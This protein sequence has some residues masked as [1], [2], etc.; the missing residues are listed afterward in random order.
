MQG[1]IMSNKQISVHDNEIRSYKMVLPESTLIFETTYQNEN[2]TITFLNVLAYSFDGAWNQNIIFDIIPSK[3]EIFVDW[4]RNHK[5]TQKPFEY[6]F[7]INGI[8]NADIMMDFLKREEYKYWEI[9]SSVG[10]NGF[11]IAKNFVISSSL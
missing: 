8:T 1:E 10:L 9:D 6:G 3:I 5:E 4:Y 2:T 7:P 11:V